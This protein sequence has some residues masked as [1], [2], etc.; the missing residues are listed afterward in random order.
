MLDSSTTRGSHLTWGQADA[1]ELARKYGTPLYV[2]DEAH[3]QDRIARYVEAGRKHYGD[4]KIAYA[5]KAFLCGAMIKKIKDNGLWM[6]VASGGEMDLALRAGFPPERLIFHGN[7][8]TTPELEQGLSAGVGRFVIDNME[9]LDR[10]SHLA[11]RAGVRPRI[12]VRVTPGVSPSTHRQIQTG[13]V[14]S[15]FG[16]LM[17]DGSALKAAR[18]AISASSVEMM[19]IHC[20][21]GSQIS[22][23]APFREAARAMARLAWDIYHETG[24]LCPEV[25]LGGGWAVQF[26]PEEHVPPLE[27]YVAEIAGAFKEAWKDHGTPGTPL[28]RQDQ[29]PAGESGR[30]EWPRLFL[31]PGRSL[32]SEGG[33]TLY[34]VGAVK[35]VADYDPY[36]LIDGGMADNPRPALYGAQYHATLANRAGEPPER[37]FRLAGNSCESD[38]LIRAVRLPEPRPGDILAVHSTGAYNYSMASNYNRFP[39]PPV[40]FVD[41]GKA[42]LAVRR[43]TSGDMSACD[44]CLDTAGPNCNME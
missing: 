41:K 31:E 32:V 1:V 7:N 10:L 14:D 2:M 9:E 4:L 39:R 21:I 19:G 37:Q 5:G 6:D 27:E 17:D 18:E 11:G 12:K 15:K 25:N 22:E 28:G 34:T 3:I 44:L 23:T 8:K 42:H 13:Q 36:I 24:F 43:E 26:L 30:Y 35:R 16:L 33:I 40:V 38:I 20:H 29:P